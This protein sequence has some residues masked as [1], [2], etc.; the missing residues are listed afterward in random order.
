MNAAW[1]HLVLSHAPIFGCLAAAPMLILAEIR[2]SDLLRKL[3]CWYVLAAAAAA[4]GAYFT[5]PAAIESIFGPDQSGGDL[6]LQHALLG[7]IAFVGMILLGAAAGIALLQYVQDGRCA[8]WLRWTLI[9][10]VIAHI[11]LLAATAHMGG[12]IRR[13]PP[14]PE[15]AHVETAPPDV[16]AGIAPTPVPATSSR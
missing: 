15:V 9:L 5:G 7:R 3:A 14:P 6:V 1:L 8:K 10:L 13:P 4:C 2:D 11:A 12:K 16:H